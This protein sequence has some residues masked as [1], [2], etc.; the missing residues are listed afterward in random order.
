VGEVPDDTNESCEDISL[1]LRKFGLGDVQVGFLPLWPYPS[2]EASTVALWLGCWTAEIA[3]TL[4]TLANIPRQ[5]ADMNGTEVLTPIV[6][7]VECV[8]DF[9]ILR[10]GA[11]VW[12]LR[13]EGD[14]IEERKVEG[15]AGRNIA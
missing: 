9:H 13:Q 11:R 15:K 8:C 14:E 1:R 12:D 2:F 10:L 7:A 4:D 3:A 5:L 6:L